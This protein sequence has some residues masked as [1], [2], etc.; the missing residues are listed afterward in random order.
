MLQE[1]PRMSTSIG[2][3]VTPTRSEDYYSLSSHERIPSKS[4]R[5]ALALP[6][7]AQRRV[8]WLMAH[9]SIGDWSGGRESSHNH[10]LLTAGLLDFVFVLPMSLICAILYQSSDS[11]D[12]R[13]TLTPVLPP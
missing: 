13:I 8:E 3:T 6:A 9:T 12:F 11:N 1:E 7:E 5:S 4:I 10:F 2:R